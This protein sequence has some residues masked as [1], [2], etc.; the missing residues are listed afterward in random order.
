LRKRIQ[1]IPVALQRINQRGPLLFL[2]GL[3]VIMTALAISVTWHPEAGLARVVTLTSDWDPSSTIYVH[4]KSTLLQAG[5]VFI[6]IYCVVRKPASRVLSLKSPAY[7][8]VLILCISFSVRSLWGYSLPFFYGYDTAHYVASAVFL[9][10]NYGQVL[11]ILF[12]HT[13][14]LPYEHWGGIVSYEPFPYLL[15][16]SLLRIGLPASVMPR[17]VIPLFSAASAIP[18]FLLVRRFYGLRAGLIAALILTF[19]PFQ[20]RFLADLYRNVIG[21]F[22]LFWSFYSILV[23]RRLLSV[24]SIAPTTL[25]F[26]SHVQ[27]LLVMVATISFYGLLMKDRALLKRTLFVAVISSLVSLSPLWAMDAARMFSSRMPMSFGF[28]QD[29]AL[30]QSQIL[31]VFNFVLPFLAP[32][33]VFAGPS[34]AKV[35][36]HT[37]ALSFLACMCVFL[38]IAIVVTIPYYPPERAL[39]YLEFPLTMLASVSIARARNWEYVAL[40]ASSWAFLQTMFLVKL[41]FLYGPSSPWDYYSSIINEMPSI[42]LAPNPS[43]W[44]VTIFLFALASTACAF[45]VKLNLKTHAVHHESHIDA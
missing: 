43:D 13:K 42:S 11:P 27:G 18:F 14:N 24:K 34:L 40:V 19:S 36:K 41:P 30:Y 10:Q 5:I 12:F 38:S 28:G 44:L 26:L 9:S 21:N 23:Q 8:L 33:I 32:A 4:E 39:F 45:L 25:L 20:F 17:L 22:F 35:R 37:F 29:L 1:L 6:I 31:W 7:A 15:F 2:A 16:A 3:I